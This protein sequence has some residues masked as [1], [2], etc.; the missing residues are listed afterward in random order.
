MDDSRLFSVTFPCT[1]TLA[2]KK[3]FGYE[4]ALYMRMRDLFYANVLRPPA[5]APTPVTPSLS[6][7]ISSFHHYWTL[8]VM[9]LGT[10][11]GTDGGTIVYVGLVRSAR[12]LDKR[13]RYI[14][15][16]TQLG[17]GSF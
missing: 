15:I 1:T 5:G 11:G 17:L 8:Y 10:D 13:L 7:F 9:A 6:H 2:F 12:P 16:E 14:D 4:G 3:A